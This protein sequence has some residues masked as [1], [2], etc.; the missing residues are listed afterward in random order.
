[1]VITKDMYAAIGR[2]ALSMA[3]IET[4]VIYILAEFN[5]EGKGEAEWFKQNLEPTLKALEKLLASKGYGKEY[6][7]F[8]IAR[9]RELA[10]IRHNLM[11]GSL[12]NRVIEIDF[13]TLTVFNNRHQHATTVDVPGLDSISDE[14]ESILK[15][16]PFLMYDLNDDP[17]S[18]PIPS[19]VAS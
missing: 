3:K 6:R 13:S 10:E 9:I 18:G 8:P 7:L 11:H 17:S 2:L 14:L 12:M 1:M 15:Q 16:V 4:M 19:I 5:F